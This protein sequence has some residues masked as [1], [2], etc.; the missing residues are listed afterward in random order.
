[1]KAYVGTFIKKDGSLRTMTFINVEDM[2][3]ELMEKK[4]KNSGRKVMLAEGQR[5]VYDIEKQEFRIFNH[6]SIVGELDEIEVDTI[7]PVE[8][9]GSTSI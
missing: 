6:K 1:M 8:Y 7:R 4:L 9:D 2:P 3:K 5:I